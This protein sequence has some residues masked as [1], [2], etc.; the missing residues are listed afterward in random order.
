[1][2]A[3]RMKGEMKMKEEMKMREEMQTKEEMKM[4]GEMKATCWIEEDNGEL[5]GGRKTDQK[6]RLKT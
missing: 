5:H 1:M 2:E 3:K 4:K 6:C